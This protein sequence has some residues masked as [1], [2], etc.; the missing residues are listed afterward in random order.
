MPIAI[1]S[2][3]PRIANSLNSL[4]IVMPPFHAVFIARGKFTRPLQTP[5]TGK[6]IWQARE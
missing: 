3:L 6:L 5:P 4:S 1:S 2:K